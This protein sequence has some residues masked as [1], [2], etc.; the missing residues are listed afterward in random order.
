[1]QVK[2]YSQKF[3]REVKT[4]HRTDSDKPETDRLRSAPTCK[5][6]L[7]EF[8]PQD[9]AHG[10]WIYCGGKI[11]GKPELVDFMQKGN[12]RHD[13]KRDDAHRDQGGDDRRDEE[14][15]PWMD[16]LLRVWKHLKEHYDKGY[17]FHPEREDCWEKFFNE[18][19]PWNGLAT[20][21]NDGRIPQFELTP[22]EDVGESTEDGEI[23]NMLKTVGVDEQGRRRFEYKNG[24]DVAVYEPAKMW[25]NF[26]GRMLDGT[27]ASV[28]DQKKGGSVLW[29]WGDY[30]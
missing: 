10:G 8:Q 23:V 29:C 2:K 14:E 12:D 18:E 11:V 6:K 20:L 13:K 1:M 27:L 7:C 3:A 5:A 26:S 9:S 16:K 28:A 21:A 30:H 22:P 19:V 17:V 25:V 24:K 4:R 15:A